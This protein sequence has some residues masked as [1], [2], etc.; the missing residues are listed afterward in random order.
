MVDRGA[1]LE[2]VTTSA[3]NRNVFVIWMYICFHSGYYITA[4]QFVQAKNFICNSLIYINISRRLQ[5]GPFIAS[6]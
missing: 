5:G 1:R 4:S 3:V 6:L 2:L